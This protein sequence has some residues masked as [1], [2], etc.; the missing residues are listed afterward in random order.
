MEKLKFTMSK[1]KMWW[2]LLIVWST[3]TQ[4]Q[5][6]LSLETILQHIEVSHPNLQ[7]LDAKVKE[8]DAYAEGARNWEAPKFGAG[9]FMTPYNYMMWSRKGALYHEGMSQG[10]G[11]FMVQ[12]EQMIP[13]RKMLDAEERYMKSMSGMETA[14]KGMVRNML[15]AEAKTAYYKWQV[16]EKK[17]KVL[18]ESQSL[19]SYMIQSAEIRYKFNQEKLS[20]IYKAQAALS[21]LNRM[22]LMLDGDIRQQKVMLNTLM[23]KEKTFDFY[24]DTLTTTSSF[25]NG[26]MAL[27]TG[28]IGNRS[29]L[30]M[31][32]QSLLISRNKKEIELQKLKPMYGVQYG[33]M[34][35]FGNQW[36]FT[37]MGMV[38]IPFAK[39]S[40]RQIKANLKGLDYQRQTYAKQRE[41]LTNQILGNLADRWVMMETFQAQIDQYEKEQIPVLRKRYQS[42]LLAYEQN[43]DELFMVLDAWMELK[44]ARMNQL[45]LVQQLLQAHVEYEKELEKR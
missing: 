3:T 21:D 32:E 1:N 38:T 37:L 9:F 16:L 40:S 45:D 44:M 4:A 22:K 11:S 43:T 17:K 29:D 5:S 15:F 39:W 26:L 2:G 14:Q 41:G 30:R 28:I 27:D 23:L 24:I 10:M 31:I 8:L 12:G 20:S 19:L 18:S 33:H 25:T 13:N 35:A 6:V 42:T 34:F 36:Q 7:Q